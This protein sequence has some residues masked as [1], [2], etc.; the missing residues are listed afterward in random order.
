MFLEVMNSPVSGAAKRRRQSPADDT[1]S[2]G[3][4]LR[5]PRHLREQRFRLRSRIAHRCA[6]L[7]RMP[8]RSPYH[9]TVLEHHRRPRNFGSLPQFTHAAD[10]I[11]AMC[12]DRLRVEVE[13]RGERI[14]ALRFSGESCAI[15]IASASMMSELVTGLD[16]A[17][18]AELAARLRSVIDGAI[19]R[20]DRLGP[21]N[22][23]APLRSHAARR[24]CAMLAWATLDAAL[25]G[26]ITATTEAAG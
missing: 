25:A 24:K 2:S 16:G 13:C 18:V 5:A 9:E 14:V 19:E 3:G 22:S 15:A 17:A 4:M 26:E 11:N 6:T 1:R 10:G 7:S 23:L 8:A 20:D 12:G 21:L